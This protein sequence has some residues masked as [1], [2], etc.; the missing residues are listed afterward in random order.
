MNIWVFA[1][2]ANGAPTTVTLELI[3]K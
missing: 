2:E 3:T 1:Q